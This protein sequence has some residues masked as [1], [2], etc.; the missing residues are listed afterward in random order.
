[1]SR[2]RI[3]EAFDEFQQ[4]MQATVAG[5]MTHVRVDEGRDV[6]E[7]PV[8][9]DEFWDYVSAYAT[10][11]QLTPGQSVQVR[12]TVSECEKIINTIKTMAARK[13]GTTHRLGGTEKLYEVEPVQTG[14]LGQVCRVTRTQ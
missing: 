12:A 11:Q 8:T 13:H 9:K 4:I 6:T 7:H 5:N 1:M 3:T 14:R 2:K 10:K